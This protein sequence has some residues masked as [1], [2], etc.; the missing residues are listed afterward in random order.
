MRIN[1]SARAIALALTLAVA[2]TTACSSGETGT[3]SQTQSN[4]PASITIAT[5]PATTGAV[6]SAGGLF[7]VKVLDASGRAVPNIPVSFSAT[8]SASVSPTTAV[9]DAS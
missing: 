5:A 6:G 2:A 3:G 8:G 7:S 9:T 4:A 1:T